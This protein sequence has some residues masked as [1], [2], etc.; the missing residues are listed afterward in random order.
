MKTG[1]FAS[2]PKA[3]LEILITSDQRCA[4]FLVIKYRV[5]QT[6]ERLD[7]IETEVDGMP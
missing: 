6:A 1:G 2:I 5:V 3:C 4:A 7:G